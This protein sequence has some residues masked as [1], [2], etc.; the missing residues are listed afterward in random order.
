MINNRLPFEDNCVEL[1]LDDSLPHRE[2]VKI[3]TLIGNLN[4]IAG[5]FDDIYT[6][7]DTLIEYLNLVHWGYPLVDI[8]ISK[9]KFEDTTITDARG[10]IYRKSKQFPNSR[11]YEVDCVG[12]VILEKLNHL[13]FKPKDSDVLKLKEQ[14]IMNYICIIG[15]SS[16]DTLHTTQGVKSIIYYSFDRDNYTLKLVRENT[17][18]E[19]E[20]N[21]KRYL[22]PVWLDSTP[23]TNF[24]KELYLKPE[25][26][27]KLEKVLR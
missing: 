17:N 23:H 11:L 4:K 2:F 27:K 9:V 24:I 20:V 22:E 16:K 7:Y 1:Y 8:P 25:L 3:E 26:K 13:L 10:D 21:I 19:V 5:L 15:H 14:L 6:P 12:Y 18:N